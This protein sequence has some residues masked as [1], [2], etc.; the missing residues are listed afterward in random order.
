MKKIDWGKVVL[1]AL[2]V[3]FGPV[4]LALGIKIIADGGE[5]YLACL[6]LLVTFG[7]IVIKA[8]NNADKVKN[9]E[10]KYI[11][12]VSDFKIK[13][14]E[15]DPINSTP[16]KMK[17]RHHTSYQ[18][19]PAQATYVGATVG[20]VHMGDWKVEEAYTSSRISGDTNKYELWFYDY[21]RVN[22]KPK[23]SPH[24]VNEV[25]ITEE[26]AKKAKNIPEVKKYLRGNALVLKNPDNSRVRELRQLLPYAHT[27]A[28][29][30]NVTSRIGDEQALTQAEM[31]AVYNFLC[32]K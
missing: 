28:D 11:Q 4:A 5:V 25:Q 27:T 1:W 9:E 6:G 23:S 26:M 21:A 15:C 24:L 32:G 18:H 7:P 14:T 22:G 29:A 2:Y 12:V 8:Q 10:R 30:Y 13:V 3:L 20:G 31:T 19:N 16:L 17:P